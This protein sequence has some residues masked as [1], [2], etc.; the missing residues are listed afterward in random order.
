ML[1]QREKPGYSV[2]CHG[3]QRGTGPVRLTQEV[4][5]WANGHTEAR[6]Q[7]SK[8]VWFRLKVEWGW[9]QNPACIPTHRV[10]QG[11]FLEQT[12]DSCRTLPPHTAVCRPWRI[13][14]WHYLI[15]H[16]PPA[17]RSQCAS[18]RWCIGKSWEHSIMY[19]H[20]GWTA[21][22]LSAF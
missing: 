1:A 12:W 9:R 18:V 7:I 2:A 11:R 3:G 13:N 16:K 17:G 8:P 21:F 14:M 22:F 20:Q 5:H 6:T 15:N 4:M 10:M 19:S